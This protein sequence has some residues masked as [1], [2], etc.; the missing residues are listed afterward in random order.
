MNV[1]IQVLLGKNHQCDLCRI[2]F[3]KILH[4]KQPLLKTGNTEVTT[5]YSFLMLS[6]NA[7]MSSL[8]HFTLTVHDLYF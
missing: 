5:A 2:T 3:E 8:S 1:K 7:S 6:V 4:Q